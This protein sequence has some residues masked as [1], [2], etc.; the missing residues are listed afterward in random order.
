MVVRM[1]STKSHRNNRRAHLRLSG[2]ALAV[3]D[4][5]GEKKLKHMVCPNCGKYKNREV[6][7]IIGKSARKEA[8]RKERETSPA[9]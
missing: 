3:C 2:P 6:I 5:C 7:D 9:K 8:K 4:N 1:R